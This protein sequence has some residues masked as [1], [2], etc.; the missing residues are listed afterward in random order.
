MLLKDFYSVESSL[1]QD[2]GYFTTLRINKDHQIYSGHF[3][4]RPVT[5]GV[6]LMQLFKEE[7]ER[8]TNHQLQ[9]EKGSNVKFTA[10]VDP[11]IDEII[12]LHSTFE[13]GEGKITLKGLAENNKVTAIKISAVYNIVN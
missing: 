9:L 5:P 10:V 12:I 7:L 13:E 3:P 1:Q 2:A 11:N 8:L 4:Q 6:I